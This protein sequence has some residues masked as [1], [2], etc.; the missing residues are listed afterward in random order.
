MK[1]FKFI[2]LI[3]IVFL[4]VSKADA[5]VTETDPFPET[6]LFAPPAKFI[7]K[8]SEASAYEFR[9]ISGRDYSPLSESLLRSSSTTPPLKKLRLKISKMKLKHK[10]GNT[11]NIANEELTDGEV[12]TEDNVKN[13]IPE[14][15]QN[16]ILS[17][18]DMYYSHANAVMQ[19]R[20]NVV[21]EFQEQGA[22]L[23]ADELNFYN[24]DNIIIATG[25]VKVVKD[26]Q[27]IFGDY[28]KVDLNTENIL[29]DK[30]YTKFFKVTIAAKQSCLVGNDLIQDEGTIEITD[31]LPINIYPQGKLR[32]LRDLMVKEENK[33]YLTKK[34]EN[35]T[36][37]IKVGKITLDSKKDN[38]ILYLK[39]AEFFLK[40]KKILKVPHIRFCTNKNGDYIEGNYPEIGSMQD[41]G[42]YVGPGWAFDLPK[43]ATLKVAP[44]FV[45]KDKVG[46]G[47]LAKFKNGTNETELY[48]G[49][50]QHLWVLRG[51]QRLDDNLYFQ[52]GA[53]H[54][55]DDWFLGRNKAK[56]GF[57]LVYGR[58]YESDNFLYKNLKAKVTT[59]TDLGIFQDARHDKY[60]SKLKGREIGTFRART[61]L[62]GIFDV[63]DYT[64]PENLITAN[65]K[66][67]AQGSAAIYGTGDTQFIG[68]LGPRVRTQY[69][70]WMQDVGYFQSVYS[71][72]TPMPVF[73]KY[74]YGNSNIYAH[75]YI[76]ICKYLT[77]ALIGAYNLSDDYYGK[78]RF[79]ECGVYASIGPD[80]LRLDV[81][82]DFIREHAYVNIQ[83]LMNAKGAKVSYDKLVIK[84]IDNCHTN[85]DNTTYEAAN[86]KNGTDKL[87]RYAETED[88]NEYANEL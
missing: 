11:E 58:A 24:N 79:S 62:E 55:L 70:R 77:L 45:V 34:I 39:D 33:V 9:E 50:S 32:Y 51:K 69:K 37:K 82:Y 7:E 85:T 80:D 81:G 49:T 65:L 30:P 64:N 54:Y 63:Y 86:D 71:D 14:E 53:N 75:E 21:I 72:H 19:A 8:P 6:N 76:R 61:M 22:K 5:I 4:F 68:R 48:Y 84:N 23:Y 40:G 73:D 42:T 28:I 25:N 18:D 44:T 83:T 41:V 57:D 74:R 29:V 78:N 52:Y 47:G 3:L 13:D 1:K 87:L 12:I 43:G 36:L 35:D 88:I 15:Q 26:N 16:I 46:F 27:E 31:D 17:C 20:G 10:K 2:I 56:Y 38:N 67:V 66:V 59:R 60:Y